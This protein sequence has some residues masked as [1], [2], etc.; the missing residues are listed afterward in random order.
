MSA[1]VVRPASYPLIAGGL[2]TLIVLVTARSAWP[3]CI[4]GTTSLTTTMHK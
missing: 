4:A 2:G 1:V 3:R